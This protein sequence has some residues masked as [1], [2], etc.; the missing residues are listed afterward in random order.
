MRK[1]T[2]DLETTP[3]NHRPD[4]TDV[5]PPANY[6]D[7]EK[8]RQYQESQVENE[9]RR[10]A[11]DSM[12]GQILCIG[13]AFDDR[14]AECIYHENEQEMLAYLETLLLKHPM[15]D[16]FWIGKDIKSFDL[17]WLHRKAIK[18]QLE[19]LFQYIPKHKYSHQIEDI[20]ELWSPLDNREY[21]K[22]SKIAEFLGL[23]GKLGDMDGSQVH[24]YWQ[25]GRIQEIIDYCKQDIETT[26]QIYKAI[27]FEL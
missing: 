8:I 6:K 19:D 5:K 1:L 16:V 20:S 7:P 13:F 27:N 4:P 11:L 14:P 17:K 25:E 2:L 12:Q 26:R 9:Y 24:D 21:V 3:S 23:D 22:M 18:Y 15:N 10:Q